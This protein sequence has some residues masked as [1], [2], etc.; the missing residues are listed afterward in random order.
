MPWIPQKK[1]EKASDLQSSC[2]TAAMQGRGLSAVEHM[3]DKRGFVEECFR[4]LKPGAPLVM[5]VWCHREVPPELTPEE[6]KLLHKIYKVYA[7]P[8][9]CPLS[10]FATF[11]K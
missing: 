8:Y 7:L 6:T 4:V 2:V 10:D 9:V 1:K 5:A 3:P 11:A